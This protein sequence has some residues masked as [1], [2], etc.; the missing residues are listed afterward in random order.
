MF[1]LKGAVITS[2]GIIKDGVVVIDNGKIAYVGATRRVAPTCTKVIDCRGKF[3][4]PGFI[5]VHVQGAGGCDI[6]DG[7]FEAINT[8]AKTL[9]KN[10]TTSFLATTVYKT[11][12]KKQLHLD[13]VRKAM[14]RGTDGAEVLGTHLEGPF[15]SPKKCGMITKANI[16]GCSKKKFDEVLD[17]CR[18]SLKMMTVAP[19]LSGAIDIIKQLRKNRIVASIGHTDAT[20]EQAIKGF[21][22]GITHTTHVF[23]AMKG[24]HHREPGAAGAVLIDDRISVQIIADGRHL[25]PAVVKLVV[26]QK[27]IERV[28]LIT[29]SMSAAGLPDGKYVYNDLKYESK[30]GLAVYCGTDTFIGTALTLNGVIK[31]IIGMGIVNLEQAVEMASIVP[32]EVLGID[33]KKGSLEKGKDADIVV[34]DKNCNVSKT[35][36]AG[37]VIK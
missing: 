24:I 35:F 1:A 26:K 25:H 11:N 31:R 36:V 13:A 30:N 4:C 5:D 27:G 12:S 7:N 2:A 14:D 34:M 19:E 17:A 37:K 23:N 16:T 20:Y 10:G 33:N 28:A 8:I 6:L 15:I 9:A 3:I 22:A 32:A 29:D 21:D 18:G